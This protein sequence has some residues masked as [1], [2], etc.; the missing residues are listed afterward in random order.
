MND[1]KITYF[2]RKGARKA[3]NLLTNNYFSHLLGVFS[4][5]SYLCTKINA[6]NTIM[7]RSITLVCALFCLL[8][9]SLPAQEQPAIEMLGDRT[10]IYPDRFDLHGDETLMDILQ[11]V[12]DLLIGGYDNLLGSYQL[13]LDNVA[14]S[15]DSRL[16]MTQIMA[17]DIQKIQVCDNSGVAK[18]RTGEGCVI[19]IN[20][21][22]YEAGAHGFTSLQYASDHQLDGTS[23]IRYGSAKTDLFANAQFNRTDVK[24]I[25]KDQQYLHSEMVSRL[26]SRDLLRTYAIQS[27]KNTNTPSENLRKNQREE[28]FLFRGRWFH[29]FNDIGTELLTL[30]SYARENNPLEQFAIRDNEHRVIR[31]SYNQPVWLLELNSPIPVIPGLKV[32]TGVE[33]GYNIQDYGINQHNEKGLAFDEKSTYNI[34]HHDVYLQLNYKRGPL[35]LTLGDRVMFYHYRQHGYSGGWSKNSTRNMFQ[36]SAVITPHPR[37]QFQLAYYRKFTN[38]SALDVFI[39]LWPNTA[40]TFI[41]GEAD[42]EETRVN[43]FKV[44]YGYTQPNFT[45]KANGS[46]YTTSD[47]KKYFKADAS[48]YY[49]VGRLSL[50]A[51][52]NLYMLKQS[53]A[54]ESIR[55]T[56][57]T[58]RF[59][60]KYFFPQQWQAGAQFIWYSDELPYRV[61]SYDDKPF[62][63]NI[64]VGKQ[65]D[66][67]RYLGLQWHDMFNHHLSAIIATALW[68]F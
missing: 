1:A 66:Q 63:G 30:L 7:K 2:L 10:I 58:I 15:A 64:E 43:Q 55:T 62:Y 32:M 46:Y 59:V 29:T 65:F 48:I 52:Y 56:W 44:A 22:Q 12:P 53:T 25:Y 47:D 9:S 49:K 67:H 61:I 35:L 4:K 45:A 24:G 41:G 19:D 31:N 33:A 3:K 34:Y 17:K 23:N 13:R 11:L 68:K 18:G 60:P 6:I 57:H 54:G 21:R 28:M 36:A 39:E 51:G 16:I 26:T 8:F 20:L 5:T 42:L 27:Y 37:H 38:P 14:I 50:T 40:G